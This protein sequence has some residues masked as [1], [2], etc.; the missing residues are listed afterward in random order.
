[1]N[2]REEAIRR[3]EILE[4]KGMIGAAKQLFIKKNTIPVFERTALAGNIVYGTIFTLEEVNQFPEYQEYNLKE[5]IE[6][7]EKTRNAVVYLATTERTD[8]GL[9]LDLFFVSQYEEEWFMDIDDFNHNRQCVYVYN[10]TDSLCSEMGTIGF[11]VNL[12]GV[13]RTE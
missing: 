7:F 1:M 3:L 11:S 6:E 13:L 5:M 10:L 12:G 9:L 8:F 2:K 4:R